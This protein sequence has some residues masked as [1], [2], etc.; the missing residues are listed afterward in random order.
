MPYRKKRSRKRFRRRG[1]RKKRK[2]GSRTY[3]IRR[4]GI[5]L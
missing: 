2:K 1:R 3:K 4:G 5:R